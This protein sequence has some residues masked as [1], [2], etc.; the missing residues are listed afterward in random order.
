MTGDDNVARVWEIVPDDVGVSLREVSR[1]VH[2][3]IINDVVYAAGGNHIATAS[4]DH[5]VL[6]SILI[7][8][9]LIEKHAAG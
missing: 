4:A 8:D 9:E 6:V 2:L 5:T 3:G 1:V 7:P